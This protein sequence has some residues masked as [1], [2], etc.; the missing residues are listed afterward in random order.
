MDNKQNR[1]TLYVLSQTCNCRKKVISHHH[2]CLSDGIV[3]IA[4]EKDTGVCVY[5][6]FCLCTQ[7]RSHQQSFSLKILSSS[8]MTIVVCKRCRATAFNYLRTL[9]ISA[10]SDLI[11]KD[12][13]RLS[14]I[15]MHSRY[16][17]LSKEKE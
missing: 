17:R 6:L 8:S 13:P 1:E 12:T 3:F 5:E 7:V 10:E 4:L 16:T 11:D 9:F 15:L 14:G 2:H